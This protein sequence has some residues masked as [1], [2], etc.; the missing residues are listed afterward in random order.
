ML[1]LSMLGPTE[2]SSVKK[3]TQY[4][5]VGFAV[6]MEV[7]DKFETYETSD[8]GDK[9]NS[10]RIARG[11]KQVLTN[12]LFNSLSKVDEETFVAEAPEVM[13][14]QLSLRGLIQNHQ[15]KEEIMK[16]FSVLTKISGYQSKEQLCLEHGEKLSDDK[17]AKFAGAEIKGNGAKLRLIVLSMS[18]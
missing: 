8:V 6:L 2:I 18:K 17:M 4:T 15:K 7:L 16:V 10:K 1:K 11:E 12:I 13:S 5:P 14:R 9:V 3:L